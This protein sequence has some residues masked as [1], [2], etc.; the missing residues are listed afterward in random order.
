MRPRGVTAR[1]TISRRRWL[2]VALA[3]FAA[4]LPGRTPAQVADSLSETWRLRVAWGGGAA[5]RWQVRASLDRGDLSELGLLGRQPDTPGSLWLVDGRLEGR[6]PRPRSFDGFDITAQ[7]PREALLRIE[8][9]AAGSEETHVVETT[10]ERLLTQQQRLTLD[11]TG[12]TLLVHRANDD[13]LRLSLQHEDLIFSPGDVLRFMVEPAIAGVNA[14]SSLDLAVELIEGRQG[15]SLTTQ[16]QRV[17]LPVRGTT[18]VP[19]SLPLPSEPGVYTVQVTARHPPGNRVAFW[20]GG[21]KQDLLANRSFQVVVH[22]DAPV[23]RFANPEWSTVAQIDPANPRWWNRLPEWSRLGRLTGSANS[24][25]GNHPF[26]TRDFHGTTLAELPPSSEGDAPWQAYPLTGARPGEPHLLEIDLPADSPLE[27]AMR[28]YE[29]GEDGQLHPTDTERGVA[30]D[31]WVPDQGGGQLVTHRMIFWP[32]TTSPLIVLQNAHPTRPCLYGPIRLRHAPANP[33]PRSGS[34]SHEAHPLLARFSWDG[35]MARMSVGRNGPHGGPQIDDT[36]AY[37]D[38][39]NRLADFL[40]LG[41]YNGAVV[42]VLA[43]GGS[44]ARLADYPLTP[45]LN[46][47]PLGSGTAD[48]P[49]VD[50][51]RLLLEVFAQRGLTLTPSLCFNFTL[52]PL[53]AELRLTDDPAAAM[54]VADFAGRPRILTAADGLPGSPHYDILERRVEQEILRVVDQLILRYG[55]QPA[56][57]DIAIELSSDSY[58]VL[59][60]P[61]FGLTP[62]RI[63]RFAAAIDAS[64]EQLQTW[65]TDPRK[66]L[67]EPQTRG[68]LLAWR[69]AETTHLWRRVAARIEA[70]SPEATLLLMCDEMFSSRDYQGLV[71]PRL[72]GTPRL[73]D[74]YLERG[75]D[76]Q[77]LASI[78]N[79]AIPGVAFQTTSLPLSDAAIPM[80]LNELSVRAETLAQ[81][82][83]VVAKQPRWMRS[84]AV[85]GAGAGTL[86][87]L[88]FDRLG[89]A[90]HR[91]LVARW[92]YTR[93]PV[94]LGSQSGPSADVL[95]TRAMLTTASQLASS[96]HSDVISEQPLVAY[97][98]RAPGDVTVT[99]ANPSPWPITATVRFDVQEATT[100]SYVLDARSTPSSVD[101][102]RGKHDWP[103]SLAPYSMLGI[104]FH[105][106][107]VTITEIKRSDSSLLVEPLRERLNDLEQRDL[108]ARQIYDALPNP[109]FEQLDPTGNP[110]GWRLEGETVS[111][112]SSRFA[113]SPG[114][115]GDYAL[116]L[117]SSGSGATMVSEPFLA[118]PTGQLAMVFY[119]RPNELSSDTQLRLILEEVGGHSTPRNIILTGDRLMEDQ[120]SQDWVGY[121]FGVEDLPLDSQAK[122]RVK[123]ALVGRGD[124]AIDAIELYQVVF[125]LDLNPRDSEYQRLAIAQRIEKARTALEQERFADCLHE[126]ESYW[127]RF[128][129]EYLP[130]TPKLPEQMATPT[131]AKNPEPEPT[132]VGDRIRGWFRFQ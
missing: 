60:A 36:Q 51:M 81:R 1:L 120:K 118:P 109:S 111:Q 84:P 38:A 79:I 14:G 29:E 20:A 56:L 4:L 43:D 15:R 98:H 23:T 125:P 41:G 33:T 63:R 117:Y 13:S 123:L 96:K 65:L 78:R 101:Y 87:P 47:S 75:V 55:E 124:V 88:V 114:L 2:I 44:A 77:A 110:I 100:A 11:E 24:P 32:R 31:R 19:W 121:R 12:N 42:T 106:S 58:L 132:R 83:L 72:Y 80:H 70:W 113:S 82:G 61:H 86:R 64:D 68:Q 9:R 130:Q 107:K 105:T 39:A 126:V 99:V 131:N 91:E 10:I 16:T 21:G 97:L 95:A 45:R 71:R 89:V 67:N 108:T 30:I 6:Q 129:V 74:L 34:A 53:E 73:E 127:A 49:L 103:V 94:I 66:L 112:T 26:R 85:N 52:P 27:I 25:T 122:L 17:A 50:P 48:L 28:I 92:R 128:L 115:Q 22:G 76:L 62:Q 5:V 69:A 90:E 7:A 93:G 40:E 8:L 116:R 59:P 35:L 57:G 104:R 119:V 3:V 37:Y 46:S 102:P 18:P 54:I